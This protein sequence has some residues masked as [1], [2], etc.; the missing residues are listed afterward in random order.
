LLLKRSKNHQRGLL[1]L[2]EVRSDIGLLLGR[3]EVAIDAIGHQLV[4]RYNAVFVEPHRIQ[5]N[6]A[7]IGPPFNLKGAAVLCTRAQACDA[8]RGSP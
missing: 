3:I 4:T 7:G 6:Q 5:A 8:I 2:K 1:T